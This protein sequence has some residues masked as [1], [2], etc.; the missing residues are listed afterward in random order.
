M[1]AQVTQV[2][3]KHW[4]QAPLWSKVNYS[5][6]HHTENSRS[7][8]ADGTALFFLTRQNHSA[9]YVLSVGP[10]VDPDSGGGAGGGTL[11]KSLMPLGAAV[12]QCRGTRAVQPA[13]GGSSGCG[14]S[15]RECGSS[16]LQV[17]TVWSS[18]RQRNET[19]AAACTRI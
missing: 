1:F 15:D 6:S 4:H 12:W 7:T 17:R 9:S 13:G 18:L 3:M 10:Q 11:R 5:C 8:A 14:Q 16:G 19:Y 2:A